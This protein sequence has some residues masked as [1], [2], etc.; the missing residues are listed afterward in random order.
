MRDYAKLAPSFWTGE[1]GMKL[2]ALGRDEQLLA[3]FLI[4]APCANMIG[5]YHLPLPTIAHYLGWDIDGVRSA[6]ERLCALGFC[7]YDGEREVIYIPRMAWH[8]IGEQLRPSDKMAALVRR[9]WEAYRKAPAARSFHERYHDAYHLPPLDSAPIEASSAVE[10]SSATA[11]RPPI[12]SAAEK[13]PPGR[14]RLRDELFDAIAALTGSDPHSSGAFI[15]KVAAS[16]RKAEPPYTAADV[17]ALPAALAAANLQVPLTLGVVEKYIGWTRQK[18][19]FSENDHGTR[20]SSGSG[21]RLVAPAAKY[22]CI[23]NVID[24][25][26]APET[27]AA[28]LVAPEGAGDDADCLALAGAGAE[29]GQG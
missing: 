6:L 14:P 2:R 25:S 5:L 20:R 17:R 23:G 12:R 10:A 3:V 11:P 4:S 28:L 26:A 8:Q 15:G 24:A 16:L 18:P 1:T 7:T 27:T 13:R 22:D 9:T 29:A 19:Q 21:A